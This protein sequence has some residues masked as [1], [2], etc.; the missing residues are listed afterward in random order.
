[1]GQKLLPDVTETYNWKNSS[2]IRPKIRMKNINSIMEVNHVI[3]C[4][5]YIFMAKIDMEKLYKQNPFPM[6]VI[7]EEGNGSPLAKAK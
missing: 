5:G 4:Q 3:L 7:E 2:T 6:S 1:M